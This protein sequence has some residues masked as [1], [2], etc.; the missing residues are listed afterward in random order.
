MDADQTR[1]RILVADDDP[2]TL[3]ALATLLRE[4]D[5]EVATARDGACALGLMHTKRNFMRLTARCDRQAVA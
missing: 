2:H 4:A 1:S 3:D 5:Y